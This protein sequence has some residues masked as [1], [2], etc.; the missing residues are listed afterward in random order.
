MTA[1]PFR[2]VT[3]ASLRDGLAR[4]RRRRRI[5][6]LVFWTYIPAMVLMSLLGE[7]VFP[8][9]AFAWM[10]LLGVT[11]VQVSLSRCPRC[12]E[13]YHWGSTWYSSW[14]RKC[15]HCGLPLRPTESELLVATTE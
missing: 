1:S 8:W 10:A 11:S 13:R 6:W 12:G 9:A 5:V 7:W 15:M 2:L 4:I 14:T 3:S